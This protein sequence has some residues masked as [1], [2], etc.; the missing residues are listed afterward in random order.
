MKF[1]RHLITCLLITCTSSA[2]WSQPNAAVTHYDEEDGLPHGHVTQ[3]LQDSLG[4]LWFATWNGLCRYDGYEFRTFKSQVGDGCHMLTDRC[5]DIA[6]RPDGQIVCRVDEEC[7]LFDTRTYRFRD[8]TPD[9]ALLAPDDLKR[10]RQSRLRGRFSIT[11]RQGNHWTITE[12]GIDRISPERTLSSRLDIVPE[13]QVKCL[14]TDRNER[15]WVCTKD[16]AAIRIFM[17]DDLS[18]QG[19][20]GAD[21]HLQKNYTPFGA[22]V[23]CMFQ[24]ADGTLWLG[25]KPDGIFRLTETAPGRFQVEHLEGL[26]DTNVY[27]LLADGDGRLWAATFGGLTYTDEPQAKRPRFKTPARYPKEVAQR[28]R[29]LHITPDGILLA[30]TTEGLIVSQLMA[31]ADQ[32]QFQLHQREADRAESLSSSAT[33]DIARD[34]R[35]N[36]YVSTESGGFDR[37]E[38]PTFLADALVFS[39]FKADNHRL[40]ND[41]VLSLTALDDGGLMAIGSHLITLIDSTGAQRVLDAG[42]FR[43]DYRF[44]DAHPQRVK[45]GAWLFGLQD[46]AFCLADSQMCREAYSPRL[47]LTGISIQG[48]SEN[49]AVAYAD[50]LAMNPD[51]RSVTVRFAALDFSSA[52]RISYAFRLHPDAPWTHIGHNRSVVLLDLAPGTYRL[53]IRSTDANGRWLDN[54]RTLV[55]VVQPTFWESV[56]GRLLLWAIA[57]ATISA[58]AYTIVYIRRIKRRHRETLEAYLA[59]LETQENGPA[60]LTDRAR[61]T[62]QLEYDPMLRRV[63]AFI[64]ENISNENVSVGDMANAAAV[65]RS[66]LQR[67]LKQTMGV[68]PQELLHEARIK[69]ACTLLRETTLSVAEVAYQCGFSDPKYFSRCFKQRIG[70]TPSEYKSR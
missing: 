23:Y 36:Y 14:F 61:T 25:T 40:P 26:A 55:I 22:A 39:H 42:N 34:T 20:L 19:Y 57:L 59:L 28:V 60:G 31:D 50:T 35:G 44:S 6:L 29:Y 67:K 58:I 12:N 2:A 56:W 53:E 49:L 1:F 65:S 16:D 46:G 33:M 21:G 51:E 3:L 64:E 54:I 11:D 8:L 5:R 66:G 68:T 4:F 48:N 10:Y 43:S 24:S 38:I 17:T 62:P 69:H 27:S 52:E 32:M 45:G 7:F 70:Q 37:I 63:M 47:V 41:V 18:F 13:A 15:L 30:A 9:E